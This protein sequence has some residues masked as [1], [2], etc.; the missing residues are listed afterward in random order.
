MYRDQDGEI[1]CPEPGISAI[2]RQRRRC[3]GKIQVDVSE[4]SFCRHPVRCQLAEA[5]GSCLASRARCERSWRR[6]TRRR[7]PSK[8]RARSITRLASTGGAGRRARRII[9]K[10]GVA[11]GERVSPTASGLVGLFKTASHTKAG[12]SHNIITGSKSGLGILE[13]VAGGA[14][15]HDRAN[16]RA[17]SPA[18]RRQPNAKERGREPVGVAVIGRDRVADVRYRIASTTPNPALPSSLPIISSNGGDRS[19][20]TPR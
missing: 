19:P 9:I 18:S 13:L 1:A 17:G 2:D 7:G 8:P 20:A 15:G 12:T 3:I 5:G 11:G 4:A 10:N 14:D 16:H 6:P